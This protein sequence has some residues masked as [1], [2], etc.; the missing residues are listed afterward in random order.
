MEKTEKIKTI[1]RY[2]KVARHPAAGYKIYHAIMSSDVAREKIVEPLEKISDWSEEDEKII[3]ELVEEIKNDLIG[4]K[5]MEEKVE[6]I[7]KHIASKK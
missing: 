6:I 1:I 3:N 2:L 4:K 5:T 7:K